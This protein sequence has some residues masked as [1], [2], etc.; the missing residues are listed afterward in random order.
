MAIISLEGMRFHAFH[1]VYAPERILGTDY[2]VDVSV[3]TDIAAAAAT[4]DVAN[5][6]N[7]E[8]VFQICRLE[9]EQERNLI[10]TVVESIISQ[11][12]HQFATIQSL[13]V[14]IRKCNPPLG[15]RVDAAIVEQE[16]S[17]I[18]SCPRC[19]SPFICY[20]DDSCW[21][22][23]VTLHPATREMLDREFKGCLCRNCLTYY[24][25]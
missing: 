3:A 14:R 17:F 11:M 20:G 19:S 24:A 12:K 1:G 10:E 4:D 23:G 9:M 8:T 6:I 25:G 21:C 7:Y 15:G 18:E 16:V 22:Q 5:T 2:I 13:Q